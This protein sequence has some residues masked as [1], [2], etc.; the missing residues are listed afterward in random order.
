MAGMAI[1][2]GDDGARKSHV[3]GLSRA[4]LSE[5]MRS[6][7]DMDAAAATNSEGM[8][9]SSKL[10]A[11]SKRTSD[12]WLDSAAGSGPVSLLSDTKRSCS[13]VSL[14]RF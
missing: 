14:R 2:P 11:A 5:D 12:G 13:F 7:A 8:A 9:P 3:F 4:Q 10:R 6:E 1:L